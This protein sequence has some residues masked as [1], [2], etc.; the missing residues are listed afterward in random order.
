MELTVHLSD[1]L[2]LRLQTC[3]DKRGISPEALALAYIED[4]LSID[5]PELIGRSS[6]RGLYRDGPIAFDPVA[7]EAAARVERD[8]IEIEK[9]RAGNGST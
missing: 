8:V 4:W 2:L 1:K 7:A 5:Y 3:A 6:R 9:R